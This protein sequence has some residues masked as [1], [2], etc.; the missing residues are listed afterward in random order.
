M[1]GTWEIVL[2]ILAITVVVIL[3]KN[4]PKLSRKAGQ[5]LG[6]VSNGVKESSKEFLEGLNE[7]KK[8]IKEVKEDIKK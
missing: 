5:T 4:S 6:E 2:I 8:T 3:G 7:T 1:L